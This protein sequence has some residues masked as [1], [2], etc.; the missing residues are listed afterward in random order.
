MATTHEQ[1]RRILI[2]VAYSL[3]YSLKDQI[4]PKHLA[5]RFYFYFFF[6]T[7]LCFKVFCI[8][9]LLPQIIIYFWFLQN[10]FFICCSAKLAPMCGLW[11]TLDYSHYYIHLALDLVNKKGITVR[12]VLMFT[13]E[14]NAIMD[15]HTGN[16]ISKEL[17]WWFFTLKV[18]NLF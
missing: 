11:K 8:H 14:A 4:K 9:I 15:R 1:Q 13:S 16:V 10:F 18:L 3:Q 5:S 12:T 17:L 6:F 7:L 2:N